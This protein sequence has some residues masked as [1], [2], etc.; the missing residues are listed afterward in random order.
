MSAGSCIQPPPEPLLDAR[1]RP[2]VGAA[3]AARQLGRAHAARQL[4]QRERIAARLRD[5]PVADALV[6]PAGDHR[7]Q[8]R[9]RVLVAEPFEPQLRQ[10]RQLA[11]LARLADAEHDRHRLGEQPARHEP[12]HLRRRLV[13]PLEVVHE[14]Q[15]R[16]LLGDLRQQAERRQADE[17]AVGRIAGREAERDPQRVLLRRGSASSR[18]SSGAHS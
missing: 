4:Q 2:G 7:R 6:E 12:E 17:E 11:L 18:P 9:A 16:L 1:Q 14:T 13:E 15:Q 8:Q 3:E 10:A 5:D